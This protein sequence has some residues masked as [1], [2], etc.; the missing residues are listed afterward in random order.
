MARK[1]HYVC[2][3][4]GSDRKINMVG[5]AQ[6]AIARRL[7]RPEYAYVFKYPEL[8][9]P[10][11]QPTGPGTWRLRQTA[12]Y[13]QYRFKSNQSIW[14]LFSP[15]PGSVAHEKVHTCLRHLDFCFL[16][17]NLRHIAVDNA[18][19]SAYVDNWRP[20]FAHYESQLLPLVR[21]MDPQ[22]TAAVDDS[23]DGDHAWYL[24]GPKSFS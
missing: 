8:K 2:L 5:N 12:V 24:P 4:P 1:K 21:Y 9:L 11:T 17:C 23:S 14:L 10:N 15:T 16:S 19:I 18:L 13:H 22:V 7:T 20:Y 6:V 3:S